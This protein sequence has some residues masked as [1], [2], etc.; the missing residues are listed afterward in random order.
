MFA[1]FARA[2]YDT[3]LEDERICKIGPKVSRLLPVLGFL[4]DFSV[5]SCTSAASV[6]GEWNVVHHFR[7]R[8]ITCAA[9]A[10]PMSGFFCT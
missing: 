3:V 6:W 5:G 4:A 10:D 7:G 1:G 9:F 8:H 2:K